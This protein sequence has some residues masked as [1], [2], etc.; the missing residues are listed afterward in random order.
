M[1]P[2]VPTALAP[3]FYR[4]ANFNNADPRHWATLEFV[5]LLGPLGGFAYLAGATAI[6]PD[7]PGPRGWRILKSLP[8]RR[9]ELGGAGAVAGILRDRRRDA[10]LGGGWM[11]C[12]RGFWIRPRS[13]RGG[14]RLRSAIWAC[15]GKG[16]CSP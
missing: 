10:G 8:N 12:W 14:E 3:V 4:L 7:D 1:F 11:R 6:L 15:L 5:F 16:S 13:R 2:V 9:G